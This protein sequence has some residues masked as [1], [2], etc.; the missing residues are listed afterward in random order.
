MSTTLSVNPG[1]FLLMTRVT[2]KLSNT[3][4]GEVVQYH[5]RQNIRHDWSSYLNSLLVVALR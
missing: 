3:L 4:P 2:V 1:R 5:V